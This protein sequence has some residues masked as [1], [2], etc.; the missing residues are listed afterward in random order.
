MTSWLDHLWPSGNPIIS[1]LDSMFT[2]VVNST[3]ASLPPFGST[4]SR[5]SPSAQSILVARNCRGTGI[6]WSCKRDCQLCRWLACKQRGQDQQRG[7]LHHPNGANC[8]DK[9]W[10]PPPVDDSRKSDEL[11]LIR[12]TTGLNYTTLIILREMQRRDCRRNTDGKKEETQRVAWRALFI[13]L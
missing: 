13:E 12:K 7:Q 2:S 1:A 6:L 8:N 9:A 3:V 4:D 10:H 5:Y 11:T